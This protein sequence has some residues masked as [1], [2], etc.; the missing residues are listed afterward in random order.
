MIIQKFQLHYFRN[1]SEITLEPNQSFNFIIGENGSGKSSLLEGIYLLSY[2]KSYRNHLNKKIIQYGQT[3]ATAF[4][5]ITDFETVHQVGLTKFQNKENQ[6]KID[7]KFIGKQSD[8][9]HYLPIQ[10]ITPET[11][12]ILT[13]GPQVR[14]RYIDWGCFHHYP[15]F[16]KI[17]AQTK[18]LLKQR[19][20]L[21]KSHQKSEMLTY[22]DTQLVSSTLKL[23][24]YRT[25]YIEVLKQ[26]LNKTLAI[27]FPNLE[28]SI[29]FYP[30]WNINKS[31]E[32]V[33][34]IQSE[35]DLMI[36]YTSSGS[37]KADLRMKIEQINVEDRLS[38][39]Q[40]KLLICALKLAQGE[41]YAEIYKQPCV[42]LI[43]DL[44]S[45]LDQKN[46]KILFDYLRTVQAQV[47]ITA[48]EIKMIEPFI[49]QNDK[50]FLLKSGII[51]N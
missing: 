2:G 7:G 41:F 19:N 30:G 10:L 8:L 38:R 40:L 44:P 21:L 13:D 29:D 26:Y 4:A 25:Q 23:T 50:I 45:E 31:Y 48:L 14:R 12:E 9:A 15:E 1:L 33:L 20:A 5:Q 46:Q 17:W 47:F 24:E 16:S 32:D 42:Y 27:F 3:Q 39:G 36:G 37:H 51:E 43:D 22:W 18:Q 35:H 34:Q 49:Q 6:I 11:F 28:I